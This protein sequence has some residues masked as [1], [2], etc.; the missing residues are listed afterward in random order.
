MEAVELERFLMLHVT[1]SLAA[2]LNIQLPEVQV[3]LDKLR[4]GFD[5][6]LKTL[7]ISFHTIAERGTHPVDDKS[8]AP[9][10]CSLCVWA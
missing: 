9:G 6:S 1:S 4:S 7:L 2:M 8:L 10:R 5:Q 3:P